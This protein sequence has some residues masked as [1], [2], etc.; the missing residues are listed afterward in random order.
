MALRIRG[1]Q[2]RFGGAGPRLVDLG[3]KGASQDTVGGTVSPESSSP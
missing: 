2:R 1:P 3:M